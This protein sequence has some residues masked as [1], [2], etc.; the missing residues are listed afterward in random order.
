MIRGGSLLI[1]TLLLHSAK[2][3]FSLLFF[4]HGVSS[5]SL[6][7]QSY[8]S[9]GKCAGFTIINQINADFFFPRTD[10]FHKELMFNVKLQFRSLISPF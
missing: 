9:V 10:I 4:V 5:E 1:C 2:V 7:V 3:Q 8:L 6:D